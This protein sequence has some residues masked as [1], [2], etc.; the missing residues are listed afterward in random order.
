M[1]IS[2]TSDPL[3]LAAQYGRDVMAGKVV[4]GRLA[5]LAVERHYRD[6]EEGQHRGLVF[7][8]DEAS[9]ALQMFQYLKHSKGKWA[10]TAI[11][12][13][14]WQTW[15]I[16]C[17]FGWIN[18]DTGFRRF[19][20]VY[21]EV[22]RKNGKTT[23]LAGVGL[24]GLMKDRE[25]GPEIYCAATKKDQ[26]KIMFT[27]ISRMV[28]QSRPLRSRLTIGRNLIE[29]S[30][31][32]GTLLPL[33]AD[34]N[35]MDGLNPHFA[36]VDE[37]HAHKT[38]GLWDVLESAL[39]SRSQPLM[40]AITTAGFNKN[41]FCYT[42]RDYAIKVLNGADDDSFFAMIYTVDDQDIN[43]WQNEAHWIKSNP[44]L[45]VSVDLGYLRDKAKKAAAV[46]SAKAN[47]LTKHLNIWVA[48]A[49]L[50]C[51]I[52][53]WNACAA[54]YHP[55][56]MGDPVEVYLGLDLANTSDIT[57]LGGIAIMPDGKKRVFG[58]HYLPE[59]AVL[60]SFRKT[61]VPFMDWAEQGW[62]T[63]TPGNVT[64]YSYIKTDI[65]KIMA[66]WNVVAIGFDRW[67][68]SQLVNDLQDDGAPM[69]AIG[70]GYASMNAPMKELETQYLRGEIDHPNDPVIN[71]AMSNMVAE[72]DPAGNIKPAKNKSS[73][74]IDPAVAV[75][76]A[77]ARAMTA[78]P[79]FVID[80]DYELVMC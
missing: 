9:R 18:E 43:D 50:W 36:L 3:E 54:D 74:K 46:P 10:G 38:S 64:D 14:P 6:L 33:S 17:V 49:S 51:N 12:L 57:S 76:I 22:A 27:E 2:T 20:T 60:N 11:Q 40:W 29:S 39:G 52:D 62:L 71:W 69:I 42:Q 4:V 16:A 8:E 26:A 34:E 48:G 80:S 73:E 72:Q 32:F 59:D 77:Q 41:G 55:D 47:F 68:S 70:M 35:T 13:E 21:Q 45:G 75:I 58:K 30:Q 56:T 31:N 61:A 79:Q 28:K 63:L 53:K 23:T 5:R 78:D 24:F 19:K 37:L 44:N 67:N 65:A 25:G 15:N 1:T 66:K 7:D